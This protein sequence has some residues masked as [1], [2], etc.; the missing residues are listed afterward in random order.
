MPS[1]TRS[2]VT[3]YD[4]TPAHF[5]LL[6][7]TYD[8]NSSQ[9]FEDIVPFKYEWGE[10]AYM[11]L[12]DLEHDENR[13]QLT[14]VCETQWGSPVQWLRAA[15]TTALLQNKLIIMATIS[16]DESLVEAT[17]CMSHDVLQS[18]VLAN[19]DPETVSFMYKNG[20]EDELDRMLWAPIETFSQECEELYVTDLDLLEEESP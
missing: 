12:T 5:K 8:T 13:N 9:F 4:I 6:T 3:I 11:D 7:A 18:K 20:E 1:A 2:Y 15:S 14:F 10:I 17:A 16:Q 19:I